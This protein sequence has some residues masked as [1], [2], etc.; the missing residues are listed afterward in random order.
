MLVIALSR[1]WENKCRHRRGIRRGTEVEGKGCVES[2]DGDVEG[3]PKFP[4]M[5]VFGA[6]CPFL[7]S[8][9]LLPEHVFLIGE[10]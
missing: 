3:R 9:C 8:T 2:G 1:S 7:P 5:A 10:G 6:K 4:D